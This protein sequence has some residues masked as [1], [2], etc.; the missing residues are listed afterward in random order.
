MPSSTKTSLFF[1]KCPEHNLKALE[2]FL[3]KR[4]F[5]IHIES[6]I[7]EGL[8]KA[9][10]L[11]PEFIFIAWDHEDPRIQALPKL[12][13]QA[14]SGQVVP[15][16]MSNN[17]EANRKLTMC[18]INPKL[19][20]PVSGPSIERLVLKSNKQGSDTVSVRSSASTSDK[21]DDLITIKS[22]AMAHLDSGSRENEFSSEESTLQQR[23]QHLLSQQSISRRNSII[24]QSAKNSFNNEASAKL[25]SSFQEKFLSP[26]VN[27]YKT[28]AES[29]SPETPATTKPEN[30]GSSGVV[31]QQGLSRPEGL[32][33]T[34]EQGIKSQSHTS[35]I[36]ES[37]TSGTASVIEASDLQPIQAPGANAATP[38]TELALSAAPG[39]L[40]RIYGI[41][42]YSENWCGYVLFHTSLALEFSSID[43]ILADWISS[44]ITGLQEMDEKD[45][46]ELSKISAEKAEQFFSSAEYLQKATIEGS[47]LDIGFFAVDPANI[48]IELS[49]DSDLIKLATEKIPA[50]TP[51]NFSLHLHLP[52]NK[53]YLLYIQAGG[54]LRDDQKNRLLSNQISDLYTLLEFEKEYKLFLAEQTVKE[55]CAYLERKFRAV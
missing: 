36:D 10:E 30:D 8:A 6:E 26:L 23:Q 37:S 48:L 27:L 31:I 24:R 18:P 25:N 21:K 44:Q 19:Y 41:A 1:L 28:L 39:P 7:K 33:T 12:L 47:T 11:Q 9:I 3:S 16:I 14:C 32:G 15:Y 53:K 22:K 42:I 50:E 34:V 55:L 17:R 52:E 43:M 4:N 38:V 49:E 29:E 2:T 46:F 54:L 5:N 13:G 40:K 51:L 35:T 45:F 20:P